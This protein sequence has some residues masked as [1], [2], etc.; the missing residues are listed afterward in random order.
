MGKNLGGSLAKRDDPI[1]KE[2]LS[3]YTPRSLR[4]STP[5]TPTLPKPPA[6]ASAQESPAPVPAPKAGFSDQ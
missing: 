2:G 6:K 4:S 3:F 1:F 5:S